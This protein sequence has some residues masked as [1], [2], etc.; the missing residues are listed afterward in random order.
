LQVV[1][2]L[3]LSVSSRLFLIHVGRV[4]RTVKSYLSTK[5][6]TPGDE[7]REPMESSEE[8]EVGLPGY[9]DTRGFDSVDDVLSGG[10]R[11]VLRFLEEFSD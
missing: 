7:C 3:G 4:E 9:K 11:I 2:L 5:V 10:E 8:S 6:D 1:L